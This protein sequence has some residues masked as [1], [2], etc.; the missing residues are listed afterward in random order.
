MMARFFSMVIVTVV[1]L[2]SSISP[3]PSRAEGWTASTFSRVRWKAAFFGADERVN[4]DRLNELAAEG[5]E[6]VGPLG[7]G[8]VAF[9]RQPINAARLKIIGIWAIDDVD[10]QEN[11]TVEFG[12][13]GAVKI[14]GEPHA[15]ASI[16]FTVEM[17][18]KLKGDQKALSYGLRDGGEFFLTFD[19]R[20]SGLPSDQW[21]RF[22]EHQLGTESY[23]GPTNS[24]AKFAF[25]GA[26]LTIA[27]GKKGSISMRRIE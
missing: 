9:K 19:P 8:M 25:D 11:G 6:Y 18:L 21:S 23:A 24:I 13:D 7:N 10:H 2:T 14:E 17:L 4:S 20:K 27:R 16:F 1:T 15:L 5:W 3:T 26:V 12:R 22:D